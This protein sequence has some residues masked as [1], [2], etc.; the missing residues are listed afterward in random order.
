M[1]ASSPHAPT[2]RSIFLFRTQASQLTTSLVSRRRLAIFRQLTRAVVIV[3]SSIM[4]NGPIDRPCN[5]CGTMGTSNYCVTY[6]FPDF[7]LEIHKSTS[8]GCNAFCKGDLLIQTGTHEE[9]V[10]RWPNAAVMRCFNVG[11]ST[12]TLTVRWADRCASHP[13]MFR[14]L[15]A[16]SLRS[17]CA[18]A[19]QPL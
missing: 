12:S 2:A 4:S 18:R 19:I 6:P 1:D 13:Q 9:H 16:S 17:Y 5:V 8:C 3:F 7:T 11:G 14:S 15:R 10:D